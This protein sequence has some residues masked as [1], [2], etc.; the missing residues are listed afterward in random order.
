M[1]RLEVFSGRGYLESPQE[2]VGA[3]IVRDTTL[4]KGIYYLDPLKLNLPTYRIVR[5]STE[6]ATLI[7]RTF[8]LSNGFYTDDLP[9]GYSDV[10]R[11]VIFSHS[12]ERRTPEEEYQDYIDNG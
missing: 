1:E 4:D 11:H 7:T 2:E 3:I 9:E 10:A 12:G 8:T 5:S 6:T